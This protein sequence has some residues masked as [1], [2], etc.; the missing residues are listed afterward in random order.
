MMICWIWVSKYVASFISE[1]R[2]LKKLNFVV[3]IMSQ[4]FKET[5]GQA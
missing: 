5:N 4:A 1:A 3:T 2:S